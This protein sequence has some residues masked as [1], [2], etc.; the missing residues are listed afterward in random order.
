[1]ADNFWGSNGA[2]AQQG[3]EMQSVAVVPNNG[4]EAPPAYED[5]AS[6]SFSPGY[7][8]SNHQHH[9]NQGYIELQASSGPSSPISSGPS[10]SFQPVHGHSPG[11]SESPQRAQRGRP[12]GR[13][14]G[15][16]RGNGPSNKAITVQGE[17][18]PSSAKKR[19]SPPPQYK[20]YFIIACTAADLMFLVWEIIYNGGFVAPKQNPWLGPSSAT[21]L[22]A[23]AKYAPLIYA[24]E[25]WRFFTPIFLHV[26]FIHFAMNMLTQLRVGL[27]LERAYGPHRIIPIYMF[28]GVFGNILSSVMLPAQ[29]QVGASGSLF[30][31]TGVLLADL[32]QNW[33]VVQ[34]PGKSLFS[35]IA[36]SLFS[37]ILGLIL[38]GVDNFAHL[39]GLVMGILTGFIFLPSLNPARGKKRGRLFTVLFC[40]ALMF[41]LYLIFLIIFYKRIS[42]SEWCSGCRYFSCIKSLP[43]CAQ[44][45][46][47]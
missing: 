46:S 23:G 39:G 36:G 12:R 45:T 7:V 44:S 34:N 21:L 3:N 6:S 38:P 40:F 20:P 15:R 18:V 27:A 19:V 17:V 2:A 47:K 42:A 9:P 8:R 41:I 25:W 28:C 22:D 30:G 43:W 31:F 11:H 5:H 13:G 10:V 35:L 1:M 14:R 4:Y 33:S 32:L 16:D 24:G 26:G 37:F 29:L